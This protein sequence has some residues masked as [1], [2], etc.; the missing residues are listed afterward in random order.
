MRC[1]SAPGSSCC[2]L[3]GTAP[4]I[5]KGLDMAA[6]GSTSVL[7][8]VLATHSGEMCWPGRLVHVPQG[9]RLHRP[10]HSTCEMSSWLVDNAIVLCTVAKD[11]PV[12]H[13]NSGRSA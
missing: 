9:T 2:R 10:A 5:T 1:G 12:C 6:Q 8:E 13:R 7:N 4:H 11:Q 3:A